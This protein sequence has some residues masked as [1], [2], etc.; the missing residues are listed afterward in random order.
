MKIIETSIFTKNVKNL[1]SD[2]E[3]RLLQNALIKNPEIGKVMKGTGGLRKV[4]WGIKGKGKSGGIRT[5]YYWFKANEIIL[6]LL[7]YQ[8]NEQDNLTTAQTKILKNIVD[9]EFL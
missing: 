5:I 3:Y 1:L 6:M 2:D 8:K 7:I 9:E 4:R